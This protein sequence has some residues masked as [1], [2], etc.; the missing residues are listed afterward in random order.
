MKKFKNP[1]INI[2]VFVLVFLFLLCGIFSRNFV[3][4][5]WWYIKDNL[6]TASSFSELVEM[7]IADID[8]YSK[9]L[10]Y[11][12]E[13]IN[14]NS[15]VLKITGTE[16]IDKGLIVAKMSNGYL[17]TPLDRID[18]DKLDLYACNVEQLN[19]FLKEKSI[20]F[21]YVMA[22]E[23]GYSASFPNGMESCLLENCQGFLERLDEKNVPYL[24]L[25]E[26][27]EA[28]CITEEEAFFVTDHHWT[29][30]TGF[31]AAEEICKELNKSYGFS[32]ES[33]FFDLDNYNV[34]TYEDWFLGS[35][36]KKVGLYF[37]DFGADDIDLIT[38]KFDTDFTVTRPIE[39][40]TD[41][42]SFEETLIVMEGIEKKDY[43]S[44][45]PYATYSG[46]D[47][48]IQ[49]VR[50][51][52]NTSGKKI[53]ILRNSFASVVTPFL[54]LAAKE[55]HILDLRVEDFMKGERVSS[56]S[57]YIEKVDPDY[58]IVLYS[59]VPHSDNEPEGSMFFR[60]E[61]E[62]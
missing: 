42:G 37:T 56:V 36:G 6:K 43:Y 4:T 58:V 51:H 21:L 29:P 1:N 3:S 26:A 48:H 44:A 22:P 40:K 53:L 46:G 2:A 30:N 20:P 49:I 52:N 8:T 61:L 35:L 41:T 13:L 27:L 62:D 54:S 55:L 24:N 9:N 59:G 17:G 34:K 45:N 5:M 10:T 11:K 19:D 31:I 32:Y 12:D 39:N 28:K 33:A 50:N 38:P 23:K 18:D 16:A 14:L 47:F 60:F 15:F 7:T 25:I 57:S